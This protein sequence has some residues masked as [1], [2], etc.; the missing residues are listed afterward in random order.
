MKELNKEITR[1]ISGAELMEFRGTL[2]EASKNIKKRNIDFSH[3]VHFSNERMQI[4]FCDPE[5]TSAEVEAEVNSRV[6]NKNPTILGTKRK[7]SDL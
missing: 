3:C 1:S 7:H 4:T 6:I 2:E 5:R